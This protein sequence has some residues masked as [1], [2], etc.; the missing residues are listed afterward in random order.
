ME[1]SKRRRSKSCFNNGSTKKK[2]DPI[3]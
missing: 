2:P 3:Q 1:I